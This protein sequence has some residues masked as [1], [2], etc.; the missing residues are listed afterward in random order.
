MVRTIGS[1]E[2]GILLSLR[3]PVKLPAID[4]HAPD[5]IAVSVEEFG[6]RVHDD[7]RAMFE[8][9]TQRRG[10]HRVVNHKRHAAIMRDLG[11]R[12]DV[13]NHAAGIGEALDKD[14]PRLIID[15]SGYVRRI[16][17]IDKAGF[18]SELAKRF[19]Q[20]IE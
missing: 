2:R 1:C 4:D 20:L 15:C 5:C 19:A 11:N 18:P 17:R 7:I 6:G 12:F 13:L 3:L 14:D 9:T 8:R 16:I 10:R